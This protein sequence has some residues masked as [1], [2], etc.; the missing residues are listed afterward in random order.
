[1]LFRSDNILKGV[2]F[3]VLKVFQID[4]LFFLFDLFVVVSA[5]AMPCV[6]E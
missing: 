6:F 2:N 4:F 3:L 5:S 1:M